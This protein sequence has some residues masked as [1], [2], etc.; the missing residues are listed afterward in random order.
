MV[1]KINLSIPGAG[2]ESVWFARASVISKKLQF[3]KVGGLKQ[4]ECIVLHCQ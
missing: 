1:K 3:N 4:Q 2:K